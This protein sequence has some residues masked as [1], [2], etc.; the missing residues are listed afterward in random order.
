MKQTFISSIIFN[1]V[2]IFIVNVHIVVAQSKSV[3]ITVDLKPVEE[4]NLNVFHD[5]IRWN[6]PGSMRTNFLNSLASKLYEARDREIAQ[7]HTKRDW[8]DR[9][10]KMK[11][12][13]LESIGIFPEKTPLNP[14]ITGIINKDGYRI[15]KILFES[16]PGFY[17][18]G[19]LFIPEN[20]NTTLPA[21]LNLIGHEQ[22][23]YHEPLDQVIIQ[24]L[25]KKGMIVFTIDPLGQGE[26]VQYF[27]PKINFS[28][29]GYSVIEHSYFGN[30]CFLSGESSA[31][32]FIW[33]GIRAIDYLVSRSEVDPERIGVTGFSGGG[34][35]TNYLAALDPRVKVS[36]PSSWSNTC[37]RVSEMKG[38]QD[39]ETF[40]IHGLKKGITVEDLLEVRAPKPTLLTFTSRDEY[41]S[42]QGA[43][44][45]YREA[46]KAYVS[47]G[48]A[49]QLD[50]VEDDSKHWLTPKIRLAIYSFFM[51]HFNMPGDPA[52]VEAEI[53]PGKELLVTASGQIATSIGG[54]MV[55][56]INKKSS[57]KLIEHLE[58]SRK[59]ITKHLASVREKAKEISGYIKPCCENVEPIIN[60]RY[61]RNGYTVNKYALPGEGDYAIPFLLF[62]PDDLKPKHRAI[63]YL[64]ADGKAKEAKPG[65]E[66]EELV[67]KGYIVAAADLLGVGETVCS[68]TRGMADA[69][70]GVLIGRSLVGIQAGDIV[71]VV[72]YLKLHTGV[73]PLQ[74]VAV[75]N[76]EMCLP[77]LHAAVFDPSIK[78]VIL[79]SPLISYRSIIMNRIHKIGLTARKG[80]GYHHPYEVDFSW[81]IAGV[82]RGYDLPDLMGC[83]APRKLVLANLMNELLE[84][85]SDEVLGQELEFPRAVYGVKKE[86]GS[87]KVIDGYE[88]L[89]ILVNWSFE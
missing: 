44:D 54:N 39:A 84:S 4:E 9:Q 85:A 66:I 1:I 80:G 61:Q 18:T 12:K 56:D 52:E 32:Y 74:I 10:I 71:R 28:S 41:L 42:L 34:T 16:R 48:A 65:G 15:E 83:I 26:H 75:A 31:K 67:M 38:T 49:D 5:W 87:L 51:K 82:L 68:V 89:S 50:M 72:N 22:E 25:V 58:L 60:G 53:I 77:L 40:F 47:F 20:R 62:V 79:I 14:K 7:L 59:S 81:G 13:L 69:Y 17:V 45:T 30:L 24:N 63:V 21:V 64:H 36:I 33:D 55:F 37:R 73:D 11:G 76:K 43:R 27:D 3:N 29:I 23:S 35:V 88:S 70:T 57:Q 8:Q 2:F 19:C 6:A 78:S 86:S 46:K